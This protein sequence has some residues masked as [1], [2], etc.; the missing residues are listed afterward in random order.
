VNS[1]TPLT[2]RSARAVLSS[3]LDHVMGGDLEGD[4]VTNY[5]P[6]VLVLTSDGVM[7]GHDGLRRLARKLRAYDRDT[8]YKYGQICVAGELGILP[9]TLI[10]PDDVTYDG[11]DTFLV[12]SGYIW[13]QASHYIAH[14]A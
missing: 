4:L 5:A 1:Y 7:A 8:S 10:G 6:A 3:H 12:R 9:W 14:D 11:A 13:T 2:V